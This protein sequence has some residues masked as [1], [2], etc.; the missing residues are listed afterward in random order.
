MSR[1]FCADYITFLAECLKIDRQVLVEA[2]DTALSKLAD[3]AVKSQ[4]IPKD[5]ATAPEPTP[6]KA[7]AK[8]KK[9]PAVKDSKA[10]PKKSEPKESPKKT[11]KKKTAKAPPDTIHYCE[12]VNR[13]GDLCGG[14]KKVA[15]NRCETV[16]EDGETVVHWYCGTEKSGCYKM[17][18]GQQER[19]TKKKVVSDA[20]VSKS[21]PA[22]ELE[23]TNTNKDSVREILKETLKKTIVK[24]GLGTRKADDAD[25]EDESSSSSTSSSSTESVPPKA[26][27]PTKSAPTTSSASAKSAPVPAATKAPAKED[28][29]ESSSAS[30]LSEEL[31]DQKPGSNLKGP[32]AASEHEDDMDPR[33]GT[34]AGAK[35]TTTASAASSAPTTKPAAKSAPQAAK[36]AK[37]VVEPDVSISAIDE[38]AS[39]SMESDS[40]SSSSEESS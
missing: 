38:G 9:E 14:G 4:K 1:L 29:E 32:T 6:A 39:V 7:K 2:M 16:N 22:P 15:K 20:R 10:S 37:K 24:E 17:E 33:K 11:T 28:D 36:P 8:A 3:S 25:A 23:Q 21:A 12:R 5:T 30:L 34:G 26:A 19:T 31:V 18:L 13:K 35:K 40:D 27:A